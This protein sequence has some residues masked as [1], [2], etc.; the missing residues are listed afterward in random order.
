MGIHDV[1]DFK[2]YLWNK[3]EC[4]KSML[5]DLLCTNGRKESEFVDRLSPNTIKLKLGCLFSKYMKSKPCNWS[6][7][8][9]NNHW[10]TE[11]SM[12]ELWRIKRNSV[13]NK[14]FIGTFTYMLKKEY[15]IKRNKIRVAGIL[16]EATTELLN[17]FEKK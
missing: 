5:L 13:C 4:E 6:V 3:L 16:N 12:T 2:G 1:H 17:I 7:I 14:E 11:C 8:K 15:K 10:I 9:D